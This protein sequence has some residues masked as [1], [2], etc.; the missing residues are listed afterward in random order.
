VPVRL[1]AAGLSVT[2]VEGAEQREEVAEPRS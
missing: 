1:A 2:V